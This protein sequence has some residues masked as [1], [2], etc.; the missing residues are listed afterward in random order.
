[1]QTQDCPLIF[2]VEDNSNYNNLILKHLSSNRDKRIE[3]FKSEEDCLKNLFK[4]PDLVIQDYLMNEMH[5]NAIENE[6]N[7]SNLNTKFVFLSALDNFSK[8][9]NQNIKFEPLSGFD[10]F[11]AGN[12]IKLGSR[13]Y[14]VKDLPA[15][16]ELIETIGKTQKNK[17]LKK[18]KGISLSLFFFTIASLLKGLLN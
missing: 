3:C 9:N 17:I 8:Q 7:K 2:V 10:K 14:V 6:S 12:T 11:Y 1:M 16:N 4:K 5:G 15:L 13:N 18:I